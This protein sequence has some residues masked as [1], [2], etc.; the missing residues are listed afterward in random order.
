MATTLTD[1]RALVR[2]RADMENSDFVS[3]AEVDKYINAAYKDLWGFLVST[4]GSEY[5]VQVACGTTTANCTAM[6]L[7]SDF[8][9]LVAL[10]WDKSS[11]EKPRLRPFTFAEFQY[12]ASANWTNTTPRYRLAHRSILYEPKP[13]AEYTLEVWYVPKC[14]QL[15]ASTDEVNEA[16]DEWAEYIVIDAAIKCGLKEETDV[17]ALQAERAAMREIIREAAP[18]RDVGEAPT[19]QDLRA[20]DDDERTVGWH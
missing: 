8:H 1:L 12:A 3:T 4:Y 15:V 7:P 14:V 20:L 11:D 16:A 18:P 13:E 2:Q 17:S 9:K 10:F 5:F 6:D 19:I